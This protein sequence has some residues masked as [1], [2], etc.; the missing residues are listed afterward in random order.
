MFTKIHKDSNTMFYKKIALFG[1]ALGTFVWLIAFLGSPSELFLDQEG[2]ALPRGLLLFHLSE[3]MEVGT[4]TNTTWPAFFQE[5]IPIWFAAISWT[6]ASFGI[7]SVI[8]Y[9]VQKWLKFKLLKLEFGI[10]S[11]A[12]GWSLLSTTTLILGCFAWL[13]IL[14]FITVYLI[15]FLPFFLICIKYYMQERNNTIELNHSSIRIDQNNTYKSNN[16]QRFDTAWWWL[17]FA[18]PFVIVLLLAAPL[19]PF[20]FDVCEYHLQVPKEWFQMGKITYLHHNVYGNMPLGSEISS[21]AFAVFFN[22]PFLGTEAGKTAGACFV[23]LSALGMLTALRRFI[24]LRAGI[25]AAIFYISTPWIVQNCTLGQ[26]DTTLAGYT[27]F[28]A[29]MLLLLY[30]HTSRKLLQVHTSRAEQHANTQNHT[31]G[32]QR[33]NNAKKY[34]SCILYPALAFA[35]FAAFFASSAAA[36]KYTAVPFVLLPVSIF[37][38]ILLIRITK[39]VPYSNPINIIVTGIFLYMIAI[40][41][42]GGAWYFKNW[43]FTGNPVY[44]LVSSIFPVPDLSQE[45]LKHWHQAHQSND[46]S[47]TSIFTNMVTNSLTSLWNSPI[48]MPFAIA[49]IIATFHTTL[50]SWKK[51]HLGI[52]SKK[53]EEVKASKKPCDQKIIALNPKDGGNHMQDRSHFILPLVTSCVLWIV[54]IF[55]LWWGTTHRL[56][57]FALLMVPFSSILAGIGFDHLAFHSR[58]VR[59]MA[60]IVLLLGLGWNLSAIILGA[61]DSQYFASILSQ[62]AIENPLWGGPKTHIRINMDD[63][64]QKVLLIGD[65]IPY[66]IR[67]PVLY[68]TCFNA[69]PLERLVS[70]RPEE[71]RR[72][73]A[74]EGVT[75]ILINWQEIA[76]YRSPGN[77]GF[78]D[79]IQTSLIEKL[80]EEKILEYMPEA[81][82]DG[83]TMF[84]VLSSP[85][86][87][88]VENAAN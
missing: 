65:A 39:N 19:P 81:S 53:Q 64:V 76:R 8:L 84:R 34:H 43:L 69:C 79:F 23:L 83:F 42:G 54:G 27:F 88:T 80:C 62:N 37:T 35:A 87:S 48:I 86:D 5:R 36:C 40:C 82:E 20:E 32:N 47:L 25:L 29:W 60:I 71:T 49:A 59:Q 67:K 63:S 22:D 16:S 85:I 10:I 46:F 68:H 44:P 21:L 55:L 33:T 58:G 26:N 75:H 50:V 66:N 13:N 72:R 11:T 45:A 7:G 77:Y 6:V 18:I 38:V 2:N 1:F 15:L 51:S 3:I 14:Y 9:T 17:V 4:N 31:V 56:E 41:V 28:S 30:D 12:F 24:S 73:L 52:S 74:A 70:D 78:T 57:R 61:T